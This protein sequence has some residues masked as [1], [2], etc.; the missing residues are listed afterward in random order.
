MTLPLDSLPTWILGS[1]ATRSHQVLHKRLAEAGV[2]GY[3]YRCLT[4]LA[5]TDHV[6][7]TQL[8]AAASLD[9]R[10]VTH[11]VRTLEARGLVSRDR[12][13]SHGR[14]LMVSLTATGRRTAEGLAPVMAAVQEEVFG[15]LGT[16]ERSTLLR[17]LKRVG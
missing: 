6:S 14:R 2:T 3:E 13:P 15:R 10:D 11:T 9:P 8:G 16:E 12:D 5:A 17:L 4:S 1:A 7:Q